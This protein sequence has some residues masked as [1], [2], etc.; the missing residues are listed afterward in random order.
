MRYLINIKT[1]LKVHLSKVK[2]G[3]HP[4]NGAST[5]LVVSA[6]LFFLVLGIRVAFSSNDPWILLFFLVIAI[7]SALSAYLSVWLFD[8]MNRIPKRLKIALLMASPLLFFALGTEG[9]YLFTALLLISLFGGAVNALIKYEL[10][11]I[12]L[13][14]RIGVVLSLVFSISG[15]IAVT[16]AYFPVGFDSKPIINAAALNALE[17]P[18]I[19]GESPANNG[20]YKVNSISYG[21]GEDKHRDAFA[22]GITLKTEA[23]NG[24]A[25]LDNWQGFSGWYRES[26][27]GFDDKSLPLNAYV[28]YPEGE[29]PFP[30]ILTV[31]GNHSMQDY[32]DD[33]YAYLGEMLASRGFIFASV[34]QNFINGSWSDV[35]GGLEEENDARGWLLLEHLRLWH[36][37][38]ANEDNP[39]YNKVDTQNLALI[40]HSR[41]GEAVAHAALLNRMPAYYDDATVPIDYNFTIKS[42][43]AIAPV[44][45]QYKPGDSLTKL[46]DINYFVLHGAQDGDVTSYLGAKQY[47]R[48]EFSQES[49]HFKAGIYVVG[50]NHGQ[51]NTGW[52][53][54][55]TGGFV[56][57]KLLNNKPLLSAQEQQQIAKVYISAFLETTLKNKREYLEL[58]I[59]HR[60]GRDWLPKTLILNQ[61]ESASFKP[62]VD[63]SVDFDVTT[64]SIDM[65][66]ISA[67]NLT[68]WR[69]Q[70]VKMKY[71]N[72]GTRAAVIGW[73]SEDDE[74][75]QDEASN[76]D[77]EI[78]TATAIFTIELD[79]NVS[80]R[81][82][83]IDKN[84]TLSL[85]LAS[86]DEKPNPKASGKWIISEDENSEKNANSVTKN[87]NAE[88][89]ANNSDSSLESKDEDSKDD[90][91]LP[92][93]DFTIR[94]KDKVGN[95]VN[96][97]LSQF[98]ALQR[99]IETQ[100][101][102]SAFIFDSSESE[103]VFQTFSYPISQLALI[104]PDF[105]ITQLQS[106]SFVF[107]KSKEGVIFVESL[108]FYEI[109][110]SS[111][112]AETSVIN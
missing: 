30:L 100:I 4:V 40:G 89:S 8:K 2:P 15:F 3:K 52:G 47:Q 98:S 101:W 81:T 91:P 38:N 26:Y 96:F 10:K 88:N 64:S 17:I 112:E 76:T 9:L 24:V 53:D 48:V 25:F 94:L 87:V 22:G 85:T 59:D 21:S 34:D 16:M 66:I 86:S 1:W 84:S 51:F 65:G 111:M 61:F 104:N 45:G 33:G 54:N 6:C 5:L 55:D 18:N 44:D 41:G 29:G 102:K 13:P 103:M 110:S 7:V 73:H 67:E 82:V 32:S 57:T 12:P 11:S 58:F 99:T 39:F 77:F 68:I 19:Q 63:F 106:I 14:K 74:K 31:H 20:R 93:I 36:E 70:E 50:A 95:V 97:P 28:W 35:F 107:D 75:V 27:W 72:K 62:I 80:A 108:G 69:E 60:R 78:G 109:K 105:D 46:K 83:S 23:V 43:V 37:W 92:P 42:I 71:G 49:E 90:V 79:E 56:S